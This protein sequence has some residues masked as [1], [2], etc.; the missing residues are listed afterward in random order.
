MRFAFSPE[1][2]MFRE[3]IRAVLIQ[4]CPP[5]AL[6][7]AWSEPSGRVPGLWRRLAELGV[8]GMTVPEALGGLGMND[9]DFVLVLEEAGYAAMPEPLLETTAV[10]VPLLCDAAPAKLRD[11]WLPRVAA[12]DAVLAVGIDDS[13]YIPFAAQADLLLLRHGN[14]LHAVARDERELVAQ[15]SVDGARRL[16]S[17]TWRPTPITRLT[18]DAEVRLSAFDRGALAA[19]AELVGI[20]RRML[21]MTVEYVKVRHQFGQP[22]GG[23]QAVKHQL[24]DAHVALALA[25]PLVYRAA[26]SVARGDAERRVHVSMAK[27]QA[28]EA[29]LG[30][31]RVALQ[32]HGAI[33]Y[34]TEYDLH[35]WMKRAWTLAS[36][37]GSAAWHRGRVGA[38]IGLEGAA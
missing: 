29:A 23:F 19:A 24:A 22:V 6:R 33:G 30:A 36:S 7:A 20:A 25:R 9:L 26:Y 34:T 2:N 12:G 32:C 11:A 4:H 8:V 15:P 28:S 14:E 37:W 17:V 35:L 5:G 3:T 16:F 38:A 21:H 27:A 31:A 18:V 10:A 13:P 1:Q